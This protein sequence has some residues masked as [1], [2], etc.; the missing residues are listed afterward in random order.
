MD[1][2][3]ESVSRWHYIKKAQNGL[4]LQTS[5]QISTAA[6]PTQPTF[7]PKAQDKYTPVTTTGT[8]TVRSHTLLSC[9][10]KMHATLKT[11]H[12]FPPPAV[13]QKVK[14]MTRYWYAKAKQN[15]QWN[16]VSLK[17]PSL[18][19][20]FRGSTKYDGDI[21]YKQLHAKALLLNVSF[22]LKMLENK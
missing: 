19:V 6:T 8:F 2:K 21:H 5:E 7:L 10:T 16:Y 15:S 11:T 14:E 22:S 20:I 3:P 9:T 17:N 18:S 13:S 4:M 12:L 1:L